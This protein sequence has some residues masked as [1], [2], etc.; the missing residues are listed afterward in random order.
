MSNDESYLNLL[1]RP[2]KRAFYSES[3]DESILEQ[4]DAHTD[5]KVCDPIITIGASQNEEIHKNQFAELTLKPI[6]KKSDGDVWKYFGIAHKYDKL[7]PALE[8]KII[9]KQCFEKRIWKRYVCLKLEKRI[10]MI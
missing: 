3:V 7:I 9:C 2:L 5:K 6:R 1:E 8:N 10:I 4:I